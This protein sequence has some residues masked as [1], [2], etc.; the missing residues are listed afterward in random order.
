MS[1]EIP[2]NYVEFMEHINRNF[3][4]RNAIY[5]KKD[6]NFFGKKFGDLYDDVQTFA[7][8]L[9]TMGLKGKNI[10]VVGSNCY[11]W[12]VTYFSVVTYVGVLIPL[13]E[14]WTPDDLKN[15]LHTVKI[16]CIVC[17]EKTL[18]KFYPVC[19]E[20]GIKT[21]EF[22][23]ELDIY[24]SERLTVSDIDLDQEKSSDELSV[25]AFT[26]GTSS[27]PKAIMLSQNNLMSNLY[28]IREMVPYD[29]GDRLLLVLPLWHIL[30]F[31][32][33]MS[34]QLYEGISVYLSNMEEYMPDLKVV[35]PTSFPAVP[36]ILENIIKSI[37]E[38]NMKKIQK[39]IIYSNSLRRKGKDKREK[40]FKDFHALFGGKLRYISVGGTNIKESVM[41]FYESLGIVV[42]QGY[43]LT[44]CSPIVSSNSFNNNIISTVGK[45]LYGQRVKIID[46]NESHI[47]EI[48]VKGRN[49]MMGYYNNDLLNQ[50]SFTTDGYFKT[51]DLG[52]FDNSGCLHLVGRKK[53]LITNL[54]G[55]NIYPGEIE[56]L[57][58]SY[59]NIQKAVAYLDKNYLCVTLVT[60]LSEEDVVKILKQVNRK[61]PKYKRIKD[62]NIKRV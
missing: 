58:M 2:R 44:E 52:Y 11:D 33:Y 54:A 53:R 49:V 19:L 12:V 51:G 14:T 39:N 62:F 38:K 31:N 23:R 20:N 18:D 8:K 43:G 5:E 7:K 60:S 4:E 34:Y 13:D 21:I 26:S 56:K 40:I 46:E 36:Y 32:I 16:D 22:K 24:L 1:S 61:L 10:A 15:V 3:R 29:P 45:V 50:K 9:Y 55:K 30:S 17:D 6:G 37:D 28:G 42:L 41:K 25:L 47:G 48:V 27:K 57:I 35:K 59:G